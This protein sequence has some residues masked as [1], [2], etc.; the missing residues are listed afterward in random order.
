MKRIENKNIYYTK[1]NMLK[2]RLFNRGFHPLY[3]YNSEHV[4]R[5]DDINKLLKN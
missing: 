2:E 1:N 5:M 3:V 4:Y